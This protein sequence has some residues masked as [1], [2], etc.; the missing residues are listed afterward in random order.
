M[1]G[2][3]VEE[4]ALAL[5]QAA[6]RH[7]GSGRLPAAQAVVAR[8]VA[9]QVL[10]AAAGLALRRAVSELWQRGWLPYD[11]TRIAG[12]QLAGPAAALV[13]DTI[14][15]EAQQYP[16]ATLHPRWQAQLRQID[17]I[18][19]WRPDRAHLGQWADRHGLSHA[20]SVGTVIA[21]LA[22]LL[23]LP[24]LPCILPLPGRANPAADHAASH[25][26]GVDQKVLAR[27]RALLAKA[28]S[29]QFPD[30]AEALSAKAQEL[31]NRHALHRAMVDAGNHV[32][33][34]AV[35]RRL[36]VD[37]PYADAKAHLVCCIAAA[38]RCR[39]A[40]HD[41]LGFVS[42]VGDH[43]D[44]E[45]VELLTTSLLVQAVRAMLSA[46][47]GSQC[48]TRSFRHSFL[49]AYAVRIG[50]RLRVVTE[51]AVTQA[52]A[53]HTVAD[54]TAEDPG[55]DPR[56]LPVLADR[57]KVV[58]ELFE[59]MFT[60]IVHKSTRVNSAAGWGAGRAAAEVAR[61]GVERGALQR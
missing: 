51:A 1:A 44:L 42:L 31:M 18:T 35:S 4:L 14:A 7:S 46:G 17:A 11:V 49:L 39:A 2:P 16:L 19:W 20:E 52:A 61:L 58:D 32:P 45:T 30:E 38:N 34:A 27:V 59:S 57:A 43:A 5:T 55:A 60:E 48:R 8:A 23:A 28:E 12:R 13:L 22:L 40:F 25:H 9:T 56:L 53:D 54:Q 47:S 36:W 21:V 10:P 33:P 37:S 24:R 29:T 6:L 50:E 41:Q 15:A 26:A 3:S